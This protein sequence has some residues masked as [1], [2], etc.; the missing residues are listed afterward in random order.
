M[1]KPAIRIIQSFT[2]QSEAE[3]F[4][5]QYNFSGSAPG[6]PASWK[7]LAD[8]LI[9][10][11]RPLFSAST[12]FHHAYGYNDSDQPSVWGHDYTVPG[13]ALGGT[14]VPGTDVQMPG[15]TAAWIRW[16]S[17]KRN[18]RGKTIYARKY[19]HDVYGD[20]GT[21]RPDH[22]STAQ[23]TAYMTFAN[24][25]LDGS[26]SQVFHLCLP[27]GT[28]LHTPVASYWL[29]TRTLKRRGKRPPT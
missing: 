3:E 4:S 19:F 5:N 17:D 28:P 16:E 27:D 11:L 22:F 23:S 25:C 13:P 20:A 9:A 29:T 15:D 6:D 14:F 1:S 10:A 26:I 12:T 18:S 2:Y 24:K 8:A 7:A 21:N